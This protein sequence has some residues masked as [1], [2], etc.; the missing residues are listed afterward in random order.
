[1]SAPWLGNLKLYRYSVTVYFFLTSSLLL[2]FNWKLVLPFS[3]L[4]AFIDILV[5]I[6]NRVSLLLSAICSVGLAIIFYFIVRY[7]LIPDDVS[8]LPLNICVR[9]GYF[10]NLINN[11][12][13]EINLLK[14]GIVDVLRLLSLGVLCCLVITAMA[15]ANVASL[16]PMSDRQRYLSFLFC[17]MMNVLAIDMMMNLPNRL[18]HSTEIQGISDVYFSYF[19]WPGGLGYIGSLIFCLLLTLISLDDERFYNKGSGV[20][21]SQ[22]LG[23]NR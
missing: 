18:K 13:S 11:G 21:R 20:T 4:G 19:V 5:K 2:D 23:G 8:C 17:N 7:H 22:P 15:R 1:M 14:A 12:I 3:A 9:T 10:D 6:N 16:P